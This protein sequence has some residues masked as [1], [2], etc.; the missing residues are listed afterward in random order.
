MTLNATSTVTYGTSITTVNTGIKSNKAGTIYVVPNDT[1]Y[2]S[3]LDTKT[4]EIFNGWVTDGSVLKATVTDP[5]KS[6][7]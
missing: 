5:A 4:V 3:S 6:V 2:T 7:S 1:Y